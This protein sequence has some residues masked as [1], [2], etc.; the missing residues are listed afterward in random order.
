MHRPPVWGLDCN[1]GCSCALPRASSPWASP[2]Q[3]HTACDECLA[4][5][6]VLAHYPMSGTSIL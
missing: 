1:Q 3:V 6:L 2:L 4:D 5:S